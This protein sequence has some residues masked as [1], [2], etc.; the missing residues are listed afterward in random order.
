[1]DQRTMLYIVIALAALAVIAIIAWTYS[2]RR[3]SQ[4]LRER[5]GP[6][7][8]RVLR[9]EGGQKKA[10]D[11]LEF[12]AK[13]RHTFNI[14]PLDSAQ[15]ESFADRWIG[16]QSNFVDN[17]SAA[18]TDA[19]LLINEVMTARGYPMS[20]FDQRAADISVDYPA[21]VEN[22]RLA[23]TIALRHKRGEAETE[24][25]RK[26]MVHYRAL[27]EDLLEYPAQDRKEKLA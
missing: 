10:E 9:H 19:D 14:R 6:E 4:Q 13:R 8:D 17:P 15:R 2:R 27:F 11:V 18:V 12:R 1:M 26:A 24:D 21:V 22:Y 16:V 3:R 7:Y 23:H 5:F 20:D 25:L